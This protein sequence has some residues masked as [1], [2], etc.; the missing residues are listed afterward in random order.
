M[1]S[2]SALL[3]IATTSLLLGGCLPKTNNP[4]STSSLTNEAKEL[5]TAIQNGRP[6][7][8]LMTKDQDKLEYWIQGKLFKMSSTTTTTDPQTQKTTTV[9]GHMI[10]DEKYVYT[11]DD[12]SSQGSKFALSEIANNDLN[13]DA[14]NSD[15]KYQQYE[16]KLDDEAGYA[17]LKAEGY[18]INCEATSLSAQDFTPP[19]NINFID[20]SAMMQQIQGSNGQIDLQK[21][22]EMAK[23]Y[24]QVEN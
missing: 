5:A 24:E 15:T 22:Q 7:H 3:V 21:L 4:P 11:W 16:P 18:T 10:N 2:H 6:T 9:N 19:S 23:Q 14:A 17:A 13:S 12:S 8:C 20:P 1:S